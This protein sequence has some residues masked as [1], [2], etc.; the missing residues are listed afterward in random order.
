MSR[1]ERREARLRQEKLRLQKK[2]KLTLV[3]YAVIRLIVIGV[4]IRSAFNGQIESVY[5]CLLTL[6]LLLLPSILERKL[7]ALCRKAAMAIVSNGV[8]SIH[9]TGDNLEDYLGIRRYHPERLPRTEQVGVVNGLAWTQVGGEILEVEVGVVPGS[10]KVELTGNLGSVMKESAQAALSYIR[11]RA[12]QLGIE[13]DFYKTKDIHVHFPEGA[14]P[15]DGPSA[16]IAVTTAMLSALTDRKIKAGI[17][18]TGEVTLRGRVL[19]IG[20]LK[21]KTMAALRSGIT[22][23]LIPKDNVRDLEE[24]DQTVRAALRFVPVET[25]DQVFAAALC[26]ERDPIRE[27]VADHVAAFAP[28]GR[29]SGRDAAVRQ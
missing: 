9:I 26:P 23:V 1:Q 15:K 2:S 6:V 8:K 22:T 13:A 7:G 24:I 18:M 16:G 14:V 17:A 21:E 25:V 5:T 4:L 10:G 12:A 20:G 3:V 27:E 29:E 11:S 28:A 19:P